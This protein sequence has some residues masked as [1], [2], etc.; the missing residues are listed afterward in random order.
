[1]VSEGF[2][3]ILRATRDTIIDKG[4]SS[5]FEL[6]DNTIT[7][8]KLECVYGNS[9]LVD[10]FLT[11]DSYFE[12]DAPCPESFPYKPEWDLQETIFQRHSTYR[13]FDPDTFW[14]Q[15]QIV[16]APLGAG[17]YY[18]MVFRPILNKDG[19]SNVY[20]DS[21]NDGENYPLY[22][23]NYTYYRNKL[24]QFE[25][26]I[27][28]LTNVFKVI[29]PIP[30]NKNTYGHQLRNILILACTEVENLLKSFLKVHGYPK[31]G[32]LSMTDYWLVNNYLH[33]SKTHSYFFRYNSWGFARPF[34]AWEAAE[35]TPLPW[36]A[37]YNRV[38]HDRESNFKEATLENAVLSVA[39]VGIILVM[40]FGNGNAFWNE[41]AGKFLSVQYSLFKIEEYYL[42]Y[43][44]PCDPH[45]KW[46]PRTIDFK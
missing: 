23:P 25:L 44:Y 36:Y 37:A 8:Y 35:Y 11:E 2:Y 32:N 24:P 39:A 1:M 41:K 27:D 29:E 10:S 28:E 38:K 22:G 5:I 13:K 14:E 33:L 34:V 15:F 18:P 21:L 19:I 43:I 45:K 17:E 16:K 3:Y 30:D 4:L 7:F 9:T 31:D 26:L 42:P 46:N 6:K 12:G 20:I 40:M